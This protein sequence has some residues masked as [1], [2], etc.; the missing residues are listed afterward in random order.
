LLVI[1]A[2]I[3]VELRKSDDTV[4]VKMSWL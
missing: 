4:G 3:G 2:V 1:E